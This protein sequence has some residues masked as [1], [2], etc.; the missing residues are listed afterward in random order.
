MVNNLKCEE[1]DPTNDPDFPFFW[2]MNG[3]AHHQGD[4]GC[5]V[6]I[7][8]PFQFHTGRSYCTEHD[9]EYPYKATKEEKH[10]SAQDAGRKTI[11]YFQTEFPDLT[12]RDI[13]AL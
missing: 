7:E 10:P 2:S 4:P 8:R 12:G 13:V 9:A 3:C 1:I 5:K 11:A 6:N